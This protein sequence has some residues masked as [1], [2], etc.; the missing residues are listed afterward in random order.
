MCALGVA[1]RWVCGAW[2]SE[3]L[4]FLCRPCCSH[5]KENRAFSL[6]SLSILPWMTGARSPLLLGSDPTR[7]S[8]P[9]AA[10]RQYSLVMPSL[11]P[12]KTSARL[13][14]NLSPPDGVACNTNIFHKGG[15]RW[16][17]TF[18]ILCKGLTFCHHALPVCIF[19]VQTFVLICLCVWFIFL[20]LEQPPCSCR[21]CTAPS[22][23]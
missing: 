14:H 16:T 21:K 5:S 1:S 2:V 18:H 8:S 17:Q 19:H 23:V 22:S 7:Q 20:I 15:R 9:P 4:S 10:S 6:P 3:L 11:A 12:D 13:E